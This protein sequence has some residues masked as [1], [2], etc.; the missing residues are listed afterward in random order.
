MAE[1]FRLFGQSDR[2]RDLLAQAAALR[3]KFE[4]AFWCEGLSTYALALDGKK[5]PCRV[6]SSNPG[7]CL[8]GGIV[9]KDRAHRLAAHLLS[10]KM[11][12]G[13]GIRTIGVDESRYN[14]MSYHDGSIWP[15]D[16]SMIAEGFARY[17]LNHDAVRIFDGMFDAAMFADL[18]RLP[19]LFC[20][21]VRR[22][23][24]GP[25][26]YPVACAPQ[27]WASAS[28][29]MLLKSMLGLSVSGNP[30]RVSFHYPRL[31][32]R[33]EMVKLRG[34]RI[35]DAS[36]DLQIE[37]HHHDVSI[38]ILRRNGPIEVVVVK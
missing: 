21:F 35:G 18:N 7:H 26:L 19:E 16:N 10:D 17:G 6:S 15:H 33:L 2:A 27:S 38:N 20:G 23:G 25:T 14:P 4:E 31:S 32:E 12:S 13:W 1:L 28:V 8:F 34:L 22:P 5:R 30:A 24:E 11:F 29:F 9:R 36:V 3:E 37:Q